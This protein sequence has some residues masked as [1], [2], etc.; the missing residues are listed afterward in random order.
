ME[1]WQYDT[2]RLTWKDAQ[3]GKEDVVF[4]LDRDGNPTTVRIENQQQP[5][6]FKRK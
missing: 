1:H 6:I 5:M 3:F 4:E 2:F